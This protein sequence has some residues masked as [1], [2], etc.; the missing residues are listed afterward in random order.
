M[1]VDAPSDLGSLRPKPALSR[2]RRFAS[3][4]RWLPG[5]VACAGVCLL[6][7][8]LTT[9]SAYGGGEVTS[10]HELKN[11]T[12]GQSLE[13]RPFRI[14]GAVVCYDSGWNQLYI[15]DGQETGYFNPHDF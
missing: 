3:R 15:Y 1:P 6:V 9:G 12:P 10:I 14:K 5:F 11:L 7:S 13:Q 2:G 8:L 4:R